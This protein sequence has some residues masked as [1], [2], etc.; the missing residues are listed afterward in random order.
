[1]SKEDNKAPKKLKPV[2]DSLI[3]MTN[4]DG[5]EH[6]FVL[7]DGWLL[8]RGVGSKDSLLIKP[9]EGETTMSFHTHP[10]GISRP[11]RVD[12]EE[13]RKRKIKV[14]CIGTEDR[15]SCYFLSNKKK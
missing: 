12:L 13:W 14:A 8:R 15:V 2:M 7:C 4:G 5:V 9:C 10:S 3:R 1:M 11:S 6:G